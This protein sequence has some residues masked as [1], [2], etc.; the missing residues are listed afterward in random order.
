MQVFVTLFFTIPAEQKTIYYIVHT[1][2]GGRG[3]GDGGRDRIGYRN[4]E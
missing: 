2:G 4:C 3:G 1:A